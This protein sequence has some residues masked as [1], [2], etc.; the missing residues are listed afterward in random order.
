MQSTWPIWK[1][2]DIGGIDS[3]LLG[4][5]LRDPFEL[6]SC[7][8]DLV[9]H[10]K[11]TVLWTLQAIRLVKISVPDLGFDVRRRYPTAENIYHTARDQALYVCPPEVGIYLR[12]NQPPCENIS[13]AMEQIEDSYG[14]P[15]IFMLTG[16]YLGTNFAPPDDVWH[17]ASDI[18]FT[19][20]TFD[21]EE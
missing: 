16:K 8:R 4:S 15:C 13:V 21:M 12:A 7:A 20:D 9:H 2:L 5:K 1:T 14:K 18:V 6:S 17:Y 19:P 10:E 3:E 11:F